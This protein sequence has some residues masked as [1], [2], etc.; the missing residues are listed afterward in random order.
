MGKTIVKSIVVYSALPPTEEE[1]RAGIV[2]TEAGDLRNPELVDKAIEDP[3]T[4]SRLASNQGEISITVVA[5]DELGQVSINVQY[6]GK[7]GLY[8]VCLQNQG[9]LFEVASG[10]LGEFLGELG[11]DFEVEIEAKPCPKT[12]KRLPLK[13]AAANLE[14]RSIEEVN[15]NKRKEELGNEHEHKIDIQQTDGAPS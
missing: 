10:W 11:A 8:D 14:V 12:A 4:R 5:G 9:E 1:L 15:A 7:R 13:Q 3:E 2:Y 6:E